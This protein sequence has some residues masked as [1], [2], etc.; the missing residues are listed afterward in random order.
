LGRDH[1]AALN[2][3]TKAIGTVGHT[4]TSVLD[5][6]NASGDIPSTLTGAN[7]YGQGASLREESP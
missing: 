5:A 7:L 1:N 6:V 3:L 4:G 2:I